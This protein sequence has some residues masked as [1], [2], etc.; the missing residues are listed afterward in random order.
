MVR[1]ELEEIDIIKI[2]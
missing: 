1:I 2:T